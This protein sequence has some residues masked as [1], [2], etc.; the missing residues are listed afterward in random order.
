MARIF[1]FA[2]G[3]IWRWRKNRADL[4]KYVRMLDISGV[5]ITLATSQELLGFKLSS[6]DSKWLRGLEYVSIHAPFFDFGDIEDA[7]L[8]K[9]YFDRLAEL[10]KEVNAKNIVIHPDQLP[11]KDLLKK[12]DF[13]I[14]TENLEAKRRNYI[15]DLKKIFAQYPKMGLCLDVLHAYTFGENEAGGLIKEFKNRITQVHFSGTYRKK[16]HQSL[17]VVT[18]IF[19][20]SIEPIKKLDVPIVIEEDMEVKSIKYLKDEVAYIKKSVL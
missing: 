10:Y 9:I 16:R 6:D 8:L 5:E 14:S 17:K 11:P 15:S 7:R 12:Y 20:R 1:S 4:I 18:S 3:N 19:L 13:K 2:L